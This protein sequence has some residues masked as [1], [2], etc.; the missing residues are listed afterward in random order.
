[1]KKKLIFKLSKYGDR[2]L[3]LYEKNP[4]FIQPGSRK[5]EMISFIK[6]GLTDLSVTRSSFDWEVK[7]SF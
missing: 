2:L 1:M 4:D 7:G 6:E 5:N 3:E